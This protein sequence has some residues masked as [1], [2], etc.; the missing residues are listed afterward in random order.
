MLGRR[1]LKMRE[2]NETNTDKF[3]ICLKALHFPENISQN[4]F[5]EIETLLEDSDIIEY[6]NS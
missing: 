1:V 3:K 5:V 4:C 6:N 2:N